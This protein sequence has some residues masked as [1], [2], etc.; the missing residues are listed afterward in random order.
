VDRQHDRNPGKARRVEPQ[1]RPSPG[2][3]QAWSGTSSVDRQN[4]CPAGSANTRQCRWAG[5]QASSRPLP[6]PAPRSRPGHRRRSPG[7]SAW[8]EAGS[9]QTGGV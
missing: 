1:L 6:A 4:G 8:N 7:A 3:D 5:S 2:R 9:G